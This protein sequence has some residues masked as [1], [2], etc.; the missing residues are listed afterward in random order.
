V[1]A[2]LAVISRRGDLS[3]FGLK[4]AGLGDVRRCDYRG[5]FHDPLDLLIVVAYFYS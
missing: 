3:E 1:Y 5:V 4:S 2:R